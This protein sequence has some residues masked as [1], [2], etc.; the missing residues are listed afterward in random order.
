MRRV[1][2]SA[3]LGGYVRLQV[4]VALA[5]V[6]VVGSLA[7]VD[8]GGLALVALAALLVVAALFVPLWRLAS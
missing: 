1:L 6:L 5:T 7:L 8:A 4:A 3:L 2:G